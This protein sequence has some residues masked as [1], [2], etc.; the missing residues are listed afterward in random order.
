MIRKIFILIKKVCKFLMK[1]DWACF[2]DTNSSI[3]DLIQVAFREKRIV[4][5]WSLTKLTLNLKRKARLLVE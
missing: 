1:I 5:S 2:S 4:R 3:S